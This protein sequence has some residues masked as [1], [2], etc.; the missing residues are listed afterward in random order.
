MCAKIVVPAGLVRPR[1][2]VQPRLLPE[3]LPHPK[4][5]QRSQT[6]DAGAPVGVLA[7]AHRGPVARDEFANAP[8][9]HRTIGTAALGSFRMP[10]RLLSSGSENVQVMPAQHLSTL[11]LTD[12]ISHLHEHL[13]QLIAYAP[14]VSR[15]CNHVVVAKAGN[16]MS[17]AS[18]GQR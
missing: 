16:R 4:G 1:R 2:R 18:S 6:G 17:A 11:E 12:V 7:L 15:G 13:G 8:G 3:R 10:R 5:L 14:T 9:D